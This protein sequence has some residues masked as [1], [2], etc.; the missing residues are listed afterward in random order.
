MKSSDYLIIGGG[1]AGTSL[2]AKLASQGSV[3]LIEAESALG[4]HSTGRSAA[5]FAPNYGNAIIRT[6]NR[7]SF[8]FFRTSENLLR[9]RDVLVI[10][11]EKDEQ[12]FEKLLS[13]G[14]Q[15]ISVDDAC[16]RMPLLRS[17][18]V[19]RAAI[20]T[21]CHDVD[22]DLLVQNHARSMRANRSNFEFNARAQKISYIDECWHVETSSG[23][24]SAPILVNAAGAWADLIA[25]MA[26]LGRLGLTPMRRSIACVSMPMDV[27]GWPLLLGASETWYA[28][29]DAGNLLISPAEEDEC[30]PMDA[31]AEDLMLAEGIDR[32]QQFVDFE[33]TRVDSNWAG[34]R[35]FAPD[36]TPIVGFDPRAKGF[37]WLAGQGGYGVQTSP[38]MSAVAADIITNCDDTDRTLI[39]ALNPARFC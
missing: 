30:E 33:V 18:A 1:I 11:G 37:F 38:A 20:D 22:V 12:D 24:Y 28:K 3:T 19:L 25:Q 36:R 21:G 13:D 2:G 16:K 35:T 29:P 17:K 8:D 4:Y 23:E 27:S 9:Q 32:F 14:F 7:K 10:C 15:E 39:E 5:M 26:G 6:L 31:W 34:L